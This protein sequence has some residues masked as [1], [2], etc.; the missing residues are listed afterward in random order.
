MFIKTILFS[1]LLSLSLAAFSQ[2]EQFKFEPEHPTNGGQVTITYDA[3]QAKLKGHKDISAIVYHFIDYKWKAA[4]LKL[5]NTGDVWSADVDIPDDCG[6]L[7]FKFFADTLID[8]NND[9]GYFIMLRDKE[10][11]AGQAIGSYAGWGLARSP[12]MRMDIPGYINFSG[13]SDTATFHWLNQ[14][15]NFFQQSKSK[16]AMPYAI[17]LKGFMGDDAFPKLSLAGA[18]LSRSDA[19]EQ[20]LLKA[21]DIYANLIGN[22]QKSDSII[23]LLNERFPKG[24]LARLAAYRKLITY[25]DLDAIL[26]GSLSFINSFPEYK[27][28][29]D[30]DA[31][32]NIRYGAIYQNIMVIGA[33][34]DKDTPLI[35]KYIDSVG[36]DI[37]P[38]VYY[39]LVAIPYHRKDIDYATLYKYSLMITE[40]FNHFKL[41]QPADLAYLSPLEYQRK[42]NDIF[43]NNFSLV[44]IGLMLSQGEVEKTVPLLEQA[45]KVYNYRSA[46]LNNL[47]AQIFKKLN[48]EPE[49]ET[50][51]IQSMHENQASIEMISMLK[52]IYTLRKKTEEGFDQYLQSLKN[53]QDQHDDLNKLRAQMLNKPMPAWSMS[54]MNGKKISSKDLLGKTVIMDFWATW[55]VPCKAS[56]PGMKLAVEKYKNDPTV[57][58]LF[59]DTQERGNQYQ[60]EVIKY[61]K[62]NN[63][64]FQ[65]L[66]DNKLPGNK[67]NSEV[68]DKVSKAFAISG[69]PQKLIIDKN[70]KLRFIS[71]GFNGSATGLADEMSNLID[72]TK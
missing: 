13:I 12:K 35:R 71:I 27:T 21:K 54:G 53:Q 36:Y 42:F 30:F 44:H 3:A 52:D 33:M 8:N 61:I 55:C 26:N 25:R 11:P 69:I 9:Q 67:T 22:K 16:L 68:F 23:T 1:F 66:F 40:R 39:K 49:L 50:L 10:H 5:N 20:D 14:E 63:Y 7:A 59:I 38:T 45:Q 51:L 70:G 2:N 57:V 41:N 60:S 31:E 6:F 17:A 72:L 58:F 47:N 24:S 37:L 62:E 43:V 32:N 15:I 34:K 29:K 48:M 46:E 64:P 56:F 19:P 18:Y 28:D 4:D 65:V